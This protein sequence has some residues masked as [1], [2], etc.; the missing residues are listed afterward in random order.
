MNKIA[1]KQ[2]NVRIEW[3]PNNIQ[4]SLLHHNFL[5]YTFGN[6]SSAIAAPRLKLRLE[7]SQFRERNDGLG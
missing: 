6:I 1:D 7:V 3:M 5:P 4:K 2:V